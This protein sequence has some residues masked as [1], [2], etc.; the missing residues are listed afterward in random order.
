MCIGI[1]RRIFLLSQSFRLLSLFTGLVLSLS[2]ASAQDLYKDPK[3]PVEKRVDDLL[4]RLTQEEKIKLLG[5]A[6]LFHTHG[7]ERLGIPPLR[8]SDGPIGVHDMGDDERHGNPSTIFAG[9]MALASSWDIEMAKQ[10]GTALGRDARARG[11]HILLGPGMDMYR[12]PYCGRNFE[13]FGEDPLLTG[14]LAAAYVQG[15]QSQGVA[16]TI[17]HFVAND[18]EHDRNHLSSDVDER[19]LREIYL[20]PFEIA[21]RNSSPWCVMDSY[22]PINGVHATNNDWLNNKVLKDEWGFQGFVMS[23][24]WACDNAQESANGGLDLE[25]PGHPK[26]FNSGKLLPLLANGAV[27]Q[28][29][30]DDKVRRILR[31]MISLGFLDRPQVDTSIPQDDPEDNVVA[32]KGAR[33]GIVL[34]KNEGHLLPLDPAKVKKIVVLGHNA[35]PAVPVGGG[36]AHV[37]YRHT[38][39][40]LQGLKD[41]AGP[42]IEIVRV[43]WS[44]L[45]DTT[46]FDNPPHK[47]SEAY[48]W[49]AYGAKDNPPLPPDYIEQIKTADVAIVCV[50]FNNNSRN[51]WNTTH[52]R[53]DIEGESV[54]RTYELPPGQAAVIQAVAKLNPRTVV[55]LNAGGSV[56][57]ASW[58]DQVPALL[59]AFYPGQAG[60][61]ALAE[62]LFGK[63]N[64]SGKLVFS[65]EKKWEDSPTHDTYPTKENGYKNTYTEGVFVGYRG[66]DARNIEPLFP[67]GFGLSYTTFVYSNLQVTP[68]ANGDLAAT[69]SMKNTGKIAGDEVAQVYITPPSSP[70][71][72]PVRELKGFARISLQPGETKAVTVSIRKSDLAYWDPGTRKWTIPPGNYSA[73]VGPSSRDL[74]L[75]TSFTE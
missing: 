37:D 17:K 59:D 22:N 18:Q 14:Y 43:P 70:T 12:A 66:Y 42:G 45:P 13:Y 34:L 51:Y 20:K 29:T 1:P 75:T 32:L 74:P 40:V 72:R 10:V 41:I 62:I 48:T 11:I 25:M 33:E 61:T 28:A 6:S 65:W 73:Q 36:S 9:G 50:G 27:T 30:V 7:I 57:T 69:F 19:T 5:G 44:T 46:D 68:G 21:L 64:P 49:S 53:P 60:G 2:P 3:A 63:T 35:D 16:A 24:W 54:E 4:S 71:P 47:F 15:V 23:D 56:E 38:V 8:M 67:F 31:V 52:S 26:Y 39:S 55:I 58:I